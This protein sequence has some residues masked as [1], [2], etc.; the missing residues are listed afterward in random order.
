[1]TLQIIFVLLVVI[2]AVVLFVSEKLPV[3]L[4]ALILMAVLLVAG[5]ITPEDGIAG[6][7]NTATVTVAAMFI[8]SSG[9]YRS[10]ALNFIS[11]VLYRL[12]KWNLW[13]A[14]VAMMLAS[15]AMSA[16][17][18]DTAVV[19][20]LMPV[21]IEAAR[22]SKSS[23]TKLL[24][25]LSFA[26]MLGGVCTLI[27]TS[28]NILV[29]SIAE[30]HGQPAFSMFEMSRLGLIQALAGIGYMLFIGIH[31][32]PSRRA[33]EDL[34][35]TF[36]MRDYLT[37]IVLSPDAKSVGKPIGESPIVRDLE[38]DILEV[39]RDDRKIPFPPPEFILEAQDVLKVRSNIEQLRALQKRVGISLRAET[40]LLDRDL[41]SEDTM[42]V[43]AVIGPT[44]PLIGKSLRDT[45]FKAT[46]GATALAIRSR[47]KLVHETLETRRL[48]PGDALLLKARKEFLASLSRHD[49]AFVVVSEIE[50]QTFRRSKILTSMLIITGVVLL[51]A[52]G[53]MKIVVSAICGCILM[54]LTGCITLEEA[55]RSIEWKVIFLLA[56]VLALGTALEK[57]GAAMLLSN[58]LVSTLGSFGPIAIVATLYLLTTLLTN[59]MS[60]NATAALLAPIAI[61]VA[62]GLGGSPRPFLMAVVF[63]ASGSFMTPVGYQTNTMIYGPGQYR[64]AD[65]LR[66]GVPLNLLLWILSTV[67]ITSI[68]PFKP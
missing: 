19:A 46:Y 61:G 50:R 51:A 25:P 14:T 43:E 18:N 15:A 26:S 29:S 65:F 23:P 6:F 44:S 4:V 20:I 40:S 49:D 41:E 33:P 8:L 55:Y 62:E 30:R 24:M 27:G 10:G 35:Q 1:M 47:G 48:L 54:I 60:N 52:L 3:D 7:S 56:G 66:V 12:S 17:I 53:I 28:T 63:A 64:F 13:V 58:L 34:T 68:W 11:T 67:F 5:V 37:E 32:L 59:V 38:I 57:T 2:V 22:N 16:F 31:L 21:V 9:L 39:A 36:G 42:L 45:E